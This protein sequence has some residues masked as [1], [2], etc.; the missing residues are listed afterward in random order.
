MSEILSAILI[1]L[2]SAFMLLAGVGVLRMPDVFMR[3]QA[4][5]KAATLGSGCT[6]L[7]VAVHFGG[8]TV[9][10]RVLVI[11]V[12]LFLTAPVA[13]HMI[14]RAAYSIGTPLWQGTIT[15]EL[16]TARQA[17]APPDNRAVIP[18]E[19]VGKPNADATG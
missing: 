4:A 10:T 13:A 6:L 17:D 14:A 15:D 16:R 3:M 5:A 2:G 1:V 19:A 11:I 18:A 9:A 8:L 7:A 12:F